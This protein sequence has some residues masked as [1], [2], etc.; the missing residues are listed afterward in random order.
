MVM[1]K[2]TEEGRTKALVEDNIAGMVVELDR[3]K[4]GLN[5]W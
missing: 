1:H 4:H 2:R 5:F 3:G